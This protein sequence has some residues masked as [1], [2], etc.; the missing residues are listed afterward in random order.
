MGELSLDD[1][2]VLISAFE[3]DYFVLCGVRPGTAGRS[4]SR[5]A[6]PSSGMMLILMSW[7][8]SFRGEA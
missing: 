7:L 1:A 3:A 2:T 8:G 6:R 5:R 4:S